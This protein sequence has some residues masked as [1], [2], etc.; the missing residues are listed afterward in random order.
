M[1]WLVIFCIVVYM[2]IG[3]ALNVLY[4]LKGIVDRWDD[5]ALEFM[6]LWPIAWLIYLIRYYDFSFESLTDWLV[7]EIKK[8]G[9]EE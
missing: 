7:E 8:D 6:F 3:F 9:A 1:I 5:S 2:S 4:R